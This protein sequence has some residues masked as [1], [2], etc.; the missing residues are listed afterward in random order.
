MPDDS[1]AHIRSAFD[2]EL[3]R[4]TG[5]QLI[6]HLTDYLGRAQRGEPMPV[7]PWVEPNAMAE[8]WPAGFSPE[9]DGQLLS[10]LQ[11]VLAEANHL[12]HP[13]YVGHQVPGPLPVSALCDMLASLLNNGMAVYE[14][15]MSGTAM[16]RS[17]IRWMAESLGFDGAAADGVLTSGGSVGNLT[18]LLAARQVQAEHWPG[19]APVFLVSDQAHYSVLRAARIMG[20]GR[21]GVEIV[22][23]DA[24]FHLRAELLE[25]CMQRAEARGRKVIAVAAAACSTATGAYDP[26]ERIAD[27]CERH[28]LWMHVDAAHG[29]AACLSERRRPLLRGVERAD[30][31]VWDAH[32]MLL[33]PALVSG[34]VFRN[35]LH[36]YVAFEDKASYLF[37]RAGQEEWFNLGHRTIE[38][39]KTMSCLKVYAALRCFGTRLF[40]EYIDY[41]YDLAGRFATMI[42]EEP[43]FE[44]ATTPE[45]NIVCFRYL[46]KGVTD[47][48]RLQGAIRKRILAEGS[49][50][51]VQ[52]QLRT[53][54]HLRTTL[55]NPFTEETHLAELLNTVRTVGDAL[56]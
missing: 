18:A 54:L 49:F 27:F 23:S 24:G 19:A 35:G 51:L 22:P 53:G 1:I 7:L 31:V 40:G 14:M 9:G 32:K 3:F 50:Y 20:L 55:I 16:E 42:R 25:E 45:S 38:C 33:M 21:D 12:H 34:V 52:T 8:R 10:V 26:L 44:L 29:G 17:V 4:N 47:P 56:R 46:P 43:D 15:G 28:Q 37:E 5:H 30:S 2:P 36:S 13:R 48:D 11:T 41:T 39:T 6:D